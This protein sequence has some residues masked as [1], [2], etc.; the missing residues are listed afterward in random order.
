MTLARSVRK[1]S[2]SNT[3]NQ[4]KEYKFNKKLFIIILTVV[5]LIGVGLGV[6]L[7]IYYGTK[8]DEA[9]V[10]DKI[11][12]HEETKDTEGHTVKF[13]KENYLSIERY[14]KNGDIENTFIFVYDGNAFYA[15]EKDEDNYNEDYVKLITRLADLQY[16]VDQAKDRGVDLELYVVDATVNSSTNAGILYD[17]QFGA[18]LSEDQA[19]YEPAF[20]Y[21]KGEQFQQKVE[22][23]DENGTTQ[24]HIIS[25]SSWTEVLNSSILYAINY[26]K[27]L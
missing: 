25:T 4:K 19:S 17:S 8:E 7:G 10:S 26:I 6:G 13:N 5:V 21:V 24:S 14:I 16:T 9:Y 22:Y 12:F 11:Y 23:K 2:R 1:V 15:D 20:I 27:T 18:L 3:N